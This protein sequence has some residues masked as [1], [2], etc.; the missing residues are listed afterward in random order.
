MLVKRKITD[1]EQTVALSDELICEDSLFINCNFGN[2]LGGAIF[3][4]VKTI[5]NSCIFQFCSSKKGGSIYCC[6]YLSFNRTYIQSSEAL[7][8]GA[9]VFSPQKFNHILLDTFSLVSCSAS[10]N[11]GCFSLEDHHDS[12]C[13]MRNMNSSTTTT[14]KSS[15]ITIQSIKVD[16][17]YLIMTKTLSR[18]CIVC[19]H[20]EQ[21]TQI[22]NSIFCEINSYEPIQADQNPSLIT[23]YEKIKCEI[24][25]STFYN[26]HLFNFPY[27][28]IDMFSN[29]FLTSCYFDETNPSLPK[30]KIV[31]KNNKYSQHFQH[32]IFVES[33]I[34]LL[35]LN[36]MSSNNELN[37]DNA[38]VV[39]NIN[40][41][42][43]QRAIY[44]C[45]Q[46]FVFVW[47]IL[48][49]FIIFIL[50]DE[51]FHSKNRKI[52]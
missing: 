39:A 6:S 44:Y 45:A 9:F 48:L 11:D 13:Y 35:K 36:Q 47:G 18:N 49:S 12:Q 8:G 15:L 51:C 43:N 23:I 30:F 31:E 2:N 52:I 14:E 10:N 41:D 4:N 25:E 40:Q 34:I 21:I 22:K 17:S 28:V 33:P 7:F 29:L 5:I 37:K 27:F 32:Y 46:F 26:I 16:I 42:F 24:I 38:H 3:S 1:E 50:R 20:R 19:R